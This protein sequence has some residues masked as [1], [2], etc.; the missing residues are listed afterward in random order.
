MKSF[1]N[2]L[3]IVVLQKTPWNP[4]S[5]SKFHELN[6][7]KARK[8]GDRSRRRP[9][10]SLFNKYYTEVY[11]RAL[12]LSLDFSTLPWYV[13]YNA[14]CQAR[15]YQVPFLKSLVWLDLGLNPGLPDHWRTLYLLDQWAGLYL[16][17]IY[18]LLLYNSSLLDIEHSPYYIALGSTYTHKGI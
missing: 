1:L 11:G 9:E 4:G 6:I 5:Q 7:Y 17:Y 16:I 13:P 18:L 15:R 3:M 8:V 14:E 2:C 12:L 10:G